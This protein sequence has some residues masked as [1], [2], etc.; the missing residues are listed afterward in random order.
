MHLSGSSTN[1][2]NRTSNSNV[3]VRVMVIAINDDRNI[4]R[5]SIKIGICNRAEGNL[6]IPAV[7]IR[8]TIK[9]KCQVTTT[10]IISGNNDHRNNISHNHHTED[11]VHRVDGQTKIKDRRLR[12]KASIFVPLDRLVFPAQQMH[13]QATKRLPV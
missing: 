5:T 13:P 7:V 12:D 2:S 3:P 11:R 8:I 9:R 6:S 1:N 10:I 4:T